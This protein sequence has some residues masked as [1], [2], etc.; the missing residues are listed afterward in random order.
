MQYLGRL[1][2]QYAWQ[3]EAYAQSLAGRLTAAPNVCAERVCEGNNKEPFPQ[4]PNR[5]YKV[6]NEARR[7]AVCARFAG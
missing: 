1:H 5:V 3:D 2:A 4:S 7:R 6:E